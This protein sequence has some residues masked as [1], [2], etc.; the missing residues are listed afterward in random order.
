[1]NQKQ[2][3]TTKTLLIVISY[4][5][6]STAAYYS[7]ECIS[8]FFLPL[9]SFPSSSSLFTSYLQEH[10]L[11]ILRLISHVVVVWVRMSKLMKLW[12]ML[13]YL[14]GSCMVVLLSKGY[15]LSIYGA[16]DIA[17]IVQGKLYTVITLIIR[18]KLNN[19]NSGIRI[20]WNTIIN[21]FSWK[22]GC[23][24]SWKICSKLRSTVTQFKHT[25]YIHC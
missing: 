18:T 4:R 2:L 21:V 6:E 22:G 11:L 23:S 14:N 12:M 24:N 5:V 3:H 13:A 16:P 1:M 8:S 20:L 19:F 17:N 9:N 15:L 7:L 10:S 25:H